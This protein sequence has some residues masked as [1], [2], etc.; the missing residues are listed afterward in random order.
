MYYVHMINR[1]HSYTILYN[2]GSGSYIIFFQRFAQPRG[3]QIVISI[4][5]A[6]KRKTKRDDAG[7]KRAAPVR[8]SIDSG[9][10]GGDGERKLFVPVDDSGTHRGGAAQLRHHAQRQ[11][12]LRGHRQARARPPPQRPLPLLRQHCRVRLEHAQPTSFPLH[13]AVGVT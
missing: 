7:V 13:A 5:T 1:K 9:G 10:G 3:F 12:P 11:P 2:I 6:G 8:A 4:S